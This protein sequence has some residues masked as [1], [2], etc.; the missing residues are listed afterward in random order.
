MSRVRLD[1]SFST[2]DLKARRLMTDSVA[3]YRLVVQL[4]KTTRDK[5][6][7]RAVE[8][9]IGELKT[10]LSTLSFADDP[11]QVRL[12]KLKNDLWNL[13]MDLAGGHEARMESLGTEITALEATQQARNEGLYRNAFEWRFE[14]PEVLDE[15][16]GF[17]G[18]DV[19]IGNP[20]YIRQE[21]LAAFKA[22]F[23]SRF[24]TYAG[25]ADLYVY[26]VEQ[27][28]NLLRTNGQFI[29]ILPNKWMRGGYGAPLRAWMK[30]R[31][32]V[33]ID[34]FGSL[35]VF[36]EAT[37]YP[38]LLSLQNAAARTTLR[39][40][41]VDTLVFPQGLDAYLSVRQHDVPTEALADGGWVL[42]GGGTHALLDKLRGA[43]KPLKE[44]VDNKIFYGIK[45]GLNEA[46]V[47]DAAT[48][49]RLINEDPRS[50][51]VIKPFLAG[52][53]IK[54]YQTP[55]S[56]KFLI[57]VE[58]GRSSGEVRKAKGSKTVSHDEAES[59]FCK[60]YPAIYDFLKLHEEKARARADKGEYWWELRA[61]DYYEEFEKPKIIIPAIVK[62]PEN[63]WDEVGFY[64]N[65]KTT[66]IST[67]EKYVLA[68]L[69]ST[70]ADFFM[71]QISATKQGG[72]FEY[73]PVYLA[74]FPIPKIS[75]FEKREV[76]NLVETI[77][78][79]KKADPTADTHA[80]EAEIDALVYRL[81]GLTNEEIALVEGRPTPTDVETAA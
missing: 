37:T 26:F 10:R 60:T 25:T 29:Y 33:S 30:Q 73:K 14:F 72:F 58:R 79:A 11:E 52:R 19:V 7:K 53:D 24:K 74:Q 45:T 50:A 22:F 65:D 61:C 6:V 35:P 1:Q 57:L 23:Q 3:R 68:V 76:E 8:K 78:A 81:Y 62:S 51:E 46:F 15:D 49:Q 48:R 18:F 67:N 17:V 13:S 32:I 47:I 9:E 70:I 36:D 39:A 27:G 69:N 20:P 54:R 31:A 77:L 56:D 66:I 5:A 2:K 28:M 80:Q 38:C 44:Y 40:S 41:V 71:Q 12:R 34:D 16:G 4:Y 21:E 43:G 75:D 64:S 42:S 55:K 59:W 63:E